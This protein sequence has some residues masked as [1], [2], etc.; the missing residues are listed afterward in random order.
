[1]MRRR[2]SPFGTLLPIVNA[3][4]CPQL[5][6]ADMRAFVRDS[7]FDPSLPFADSILL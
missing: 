3:L 6:E 1:M 5:A 2:V 7:G 4:V